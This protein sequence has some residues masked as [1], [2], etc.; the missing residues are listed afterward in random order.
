MRVICRRTMSSMSSRRPFAAMVLATACGLLLPWAVAS[1]PL[2][3]EARIERRLAGVLSTQSFE[4]AADELVIV[5]DDLEVQS[6]EDI[7]VNGP[8]VAQRKAQSSGRHGISIMLSTAGTIFVNAAIQPSSG[9]AGERSC[10]AGGRGGDLILT[11]RKIVFRV[12]EL[13]AGDGARGGA[14]APGGAG[15]RI[16]VVTDYKPVSLLPTGQRAQLHGGRG[17]VGGHGLWQVCS[18]GLTPGKGGAGGAGGSA[19]M[20]LNPASTS[21]AADCADGVPGTNGADAVGTD[22]ADGG[23][24]ANGT[25]THLNGGNGG[26]GGPGGGAIGLPGG[27]GGAGGACCNPPGPGGKGGA[28]GKGGNAQGGK[29]GS[30][31]K[32]GDAYAFGRGGNGG[33]GGNGGSATSGNGGAGG[34]GGKGSPGGSGGAGGQAGVATPGAAGAGGAAGSPG[35][36][37]GAAGS[38]GTATTGTPGAPGAS[39]RSCPCTATAICETGFVSCSGVTAC[40]AV[41]R[42][43][44]TGERGRVTCDGITTFCPTAC[45]CSPCCQCEAT[46]DCFSCCRC[47]GGTI[48]SCAQMCG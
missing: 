17:G 15:G 2:D 22:G 38:G 36:A 34:A 39:G 13:R 23:P 25:L 1:S 16:V 3:S 27:A 37:S 30:G 48:A 44:S 18:K 40:T 6:E 45:S 41:D 32:G 29:G 7:V 11:A 42:D 47:D 28:G 12:P 24:G 31:G 19:M 35:G 46:G 33:N 43:C 10:E 9:S 5:E 14:G 21:T 8:I 4:V 20:A 26:D